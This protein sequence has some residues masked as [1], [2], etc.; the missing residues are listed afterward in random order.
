MS[1]PR[2]NNFNREV[3]EMFAAYLDANNLYIL[4]SN[5]NRNINFA[6][7]K[8]NEKREE[9]LK[10]IIDALNDGFYSADS[11]L[12]YIYELVLEYQDDYEERKKKAEF[13]TN[14]INF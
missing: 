2:D 12:A 4:K 3:M 5:P 1:N 10:R 11:C 9:L 13:G 14:K 8:D 7:P 6:L